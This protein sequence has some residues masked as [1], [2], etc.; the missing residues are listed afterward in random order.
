MSKS[1]S[2][3][4]DLYDPGKS[5]QNRCSGSVTFGRKCKEESQGRNFNFNLWFAVGYEM[6]SCGYQNV[7]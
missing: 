2:T 7:D 3:V 5:K 6:I 4:I 1:N